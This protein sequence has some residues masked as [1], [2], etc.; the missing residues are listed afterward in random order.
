MSND[1]V[2]ALSGFGNFT[3]FICSLSY[4]LT[5]IRAIVSPDNLV[6]LVGET[7][8]YFRSRQSTRIREFP[9]IIKCAGDATVGNASI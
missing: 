8:I 2:D 5:Y 7:T 4:A 1:D 6:L 9:H 3:D